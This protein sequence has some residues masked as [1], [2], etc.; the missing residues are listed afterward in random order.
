MLKVS[1]GLYLILALASA[2]KLNSDYHLS[3]DSAHELKIIS[4]IVSPC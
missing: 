2:I 3:M 4:S 1:L